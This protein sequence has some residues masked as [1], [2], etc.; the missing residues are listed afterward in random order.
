MQGEFEE[1]EVEWWESVIG[2]LVLWRLSW[3][4]IFSSG[5]LRVSMV[6][7][8]EVGYTDGLRRIGLDYCGLVSCWEQR[9]S[10]R[11]TNYL[12]DRVQFKAY[13]QGIILTMIQ[14]IGRPSCR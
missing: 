3:V 13:L 5:G 4:G 8:D 12:R 14:H 2:D 10:F 1:G 9:R 6:V 11:D 7:V